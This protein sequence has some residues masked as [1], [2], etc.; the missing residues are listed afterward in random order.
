RAALSAIADEHLPAAGDSATILDLHTGALLLQHHPE[1]TQRARI[2]PGSVMKLFTG[3][4]LLEAGRADEMTRCEGQHK[5][6]MGPAR[7]CWD[8]RGH[9]PMRL[10]TAISESCNV[11]FY[12]QSEH[13]EA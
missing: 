3:Y 8:R 6:P 7:P 13:L 10:R 12:A 5:G 2:L 4:A 11:R 9:G 1:A